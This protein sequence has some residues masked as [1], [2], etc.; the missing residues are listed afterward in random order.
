[1]PRLRLKLNL[2]QKKPLPIT[3]IALFKTDRIKIDRT[4]I[5]RETAPP[6]NPLDILLIISHLI[7]SHQT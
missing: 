2:M 7:T 3:V 4:K 1:M 6:S 5:E